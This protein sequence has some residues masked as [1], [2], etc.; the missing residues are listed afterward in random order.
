MVVLPWSAYWERNY[1]V[2][3]WPVVRA[4]V[5][6]NFVRGAISGLGIVN[7]VA[8]LVELLSTVG[9]RQPSAVSLH[10]RADQHP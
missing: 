10:D 7:L 1:F 5:T 9:L 4:V 3:L 6:N 2:E 8:G